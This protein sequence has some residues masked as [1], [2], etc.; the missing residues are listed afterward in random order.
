MKH[1]ANT[2]NESSTAVSPAGARCNGPLQKDLPAGWAWSTIGEISE[3]PQYGWTTKANHEEGHLKLLRTTDITSGT[4]DWSN[5]PYCTEEPEDIEKYLVKSG[6]ILISRAGSIGVSYLVNNPERAAFAS[7]LIRFRPKQSVD[8]KYVYYYLKSPDYWTA[9]GASKVGIA[10]PNVN[11]TKL[12]QV[13]IPLAPLNQQKLIVAEI[14]KQ[15]S[16]LDEAVTALKRIQANLKRYKASVLKAAVEGA[17]TEEWRRKNPDVEPA[18]EL[19]KRLLVERRRKWEE[20]YVNKYVAAHGHV[21]KDDSWKKKYKEPAPPDTSNLP[22]LPKG[23]VWATAEQLCDFI[24]KGTTPSATKLNE[25]AGEVQFLKVYNLAF[26]GQLNYKYKPAYV[27]RATH[28]GELAR[29]IVFPGDI[30]IN[31][32][33]PPLGQVSIVPE[34]L[35]EANINQ[36]IARFRMLG[37]ML[38]RYFAIA[39]MSKEVMGWAIKRAKTTAGQANLTLELSRALPIPLPPLS[40]QEN[41]VDEVES[42]F[43]VTEEIEAAIETNLKRAERLRQAILKNAFLGKYFKEEGYYGR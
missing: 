1:R 33:G 16:R 6:D 39:L 25:G 40:E 22:K 19:L 36:A 3:R 8:K 29:S 18:T 20:D 30:L 42:R 15:F 32:V 11:A 9:I 5:V 10:V 37:E 23:W 41:I 35:P 34:A 38:G 43:S 13:P 24:T 7:Y 2:I 28:E 31:I 27:S 4:V 26:T 21:P 14:E 12:S 17:L